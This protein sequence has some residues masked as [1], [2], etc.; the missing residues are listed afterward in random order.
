MALR[1]AARQLHMW[2]GEDG[3][4][5]ARFRK[6]PPALEFETQCAL[7][8]TLQEYANPEWF[9]TAF[10]SGEK[11]TKATAGRLKAMGVKPGVS[12]FVFISPD[13]LF[14]GLELKR[15]K[16]GRLS[17]SQESFAAW[18]GRHGVAYEVAGSFDAAVA[19]LV[20]WGVLKTDVGT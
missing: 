9:W 19:I 16:L 1:V 2:I 3:K 5:K 18:C 11:R 12:D 14:H 7:V 20:G 6:P 4:K 17:A 15:G 8:R 13:G 10:P